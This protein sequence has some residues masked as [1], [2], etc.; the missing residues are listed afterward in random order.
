MNYAQLVQAVQD[1]TENDEATFVSQIPRFVQQIE[2]RLA[3]SVMIPNLRRNQTGNMTASNRFLST[4]SD[5]LA[6]F[7]LAVLN[8]DGEYEF[9]LNKDVN[10]IRE[11]YNETTTEGLPQYYALF[12]DA[13]FILGPTPDQSY[14]VQLHYYHQPESIVTAGTSWY[15]DNAESAL[16]YGVLIEAYTFMKG[17]QDL[18]NLYAKRY[19]EALQQLYVLGEGRNRRDS[20]RNGEPRIPVT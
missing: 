17:E 1:Y 19:E 13:S 15:G 8:G 16:L 11:A 20:Y 14:N 5:F 10:F 6:V 4:P 18:T 9:L 12:D 7:S 2:E 3:R